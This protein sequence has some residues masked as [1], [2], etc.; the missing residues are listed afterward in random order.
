MRRRPRRIDGEINLD[1]SSSSRGV[2][3]SLCCVGTYPSQAQ[4][5]RNAVELK[6]GMKLEEVEKLLGKP[7]RTALKSTASF[8]T[9]SSAGELSQGTLQ[10][11]YVWA[12][13]RTLH[14]EST[15]RRRSSGT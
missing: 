3:R 5:E 13:E 11:T 6:Q 4:A 1:D 12:R 15:P 9:G 2:S 14:V 10:W 7:K 8:A